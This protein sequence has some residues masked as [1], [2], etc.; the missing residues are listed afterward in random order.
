M[1]Q[2]LHL[3]ISEN[4]CQDTVCGENLIVVRLVRQWFPSFLACDP[5]DEI[6]FTCYTLSQVAEVSD[7]L[8]FF[9]KKKD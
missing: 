3:Y 7:F 5:K 8:L 6:M 2:P 1:T 4:T 9:L